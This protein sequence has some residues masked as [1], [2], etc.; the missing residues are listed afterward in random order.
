MARTDSERSQKI[1]RRQVEKLEGAKSGLDLVE[2]GVHLARRA[3]LIAWIWYF[4]GTG[5]FLVG[6]LFFWNDMAHSGL[7]YQHVVSGAF[8][9]AVAFVW[10][11][12]CQVRFARCL[13]EVVRDAPTE[14]LSLRKG[15]SIMMTQAQWQ[16]TAMIALP[17]SLFLVFPFSYAFSL[18]QNL[19]TLEA[20]G[21]RSG[22]EPLFSRANKLAG[23]WPMQAR[24]LLCLFVVLGF[25]LLLNWYTVL[26]FL[27]MLAKSLLGLDNMMIRS[28][29]HAFNSTTFSIALALTYL[30]VDPL[31]KASFLLRVH[32]ARSQHTG[33]DLLFNLNELKRLARGVSCVV[34]MLI[35]SFIAFAP[36]GLQAQSEES[37]SVEDDAAAFDQAIDDTLSQPEYI[38]RFPKEEVVTDMESP[39]W[40]TNLSESAMDALKSFGQWLESLFKE[41][42]EPREIGEPPTGF[43]GFGFGH[44]L[45]YVVIAIAVLA[46]VWGIYKLWGSRVSDGAVQAVPATEVVPDL[47]QEDVSADAL[48]RNRW[49]ELAQKLM[50]D[51]EL[52]LA[53]RALF[54]AELA[55]LA[56]QGLIS[57]SKYKSNLDYRRELSRRGSAEEVLGAYRASALLFDGAWY[58]ERSVGHNEIQQMENHLRS[59]GLAW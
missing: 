10:M 5:P 32:Y 29:G 11:R 16:T 9:M 15:A 12:Y 50:S 28:G 3:P 51:G 57:L 25:M 59:I 42:D 49:L 13:W 43:Q 27:P 4:L 14:P 52:R 23:V 33:D 24:R 22:E 58:G 36:T 1:T 41:R 48:P 31:I 8:L 37:G 17:L 44:T 40:L 30:T 46:I 26:Y 47:N 34:G 45:S 55:H 53:L 54:F 2:E 56:D 35:G 21:D 6:F 18:I 19:M 7:A 39:T 38:W 20:S